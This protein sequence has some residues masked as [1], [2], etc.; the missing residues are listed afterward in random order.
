MSKKVT[1]TE[2]QYNSLKL[3][4]MLADFVKDSISEKTKAETREIGVFPITR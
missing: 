4:T 3:H 1:L 2:K